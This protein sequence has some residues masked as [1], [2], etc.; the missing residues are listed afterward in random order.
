MLKDM[1]NFIN[2]IEIL[3]QMLYHQ[4]Y[5]QVTKQKILQFYINKSDFYINNSKKKTKKNKFSVKFFG[6]FN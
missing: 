3:R 5:H 6:Q 4:K 1:E 2:H